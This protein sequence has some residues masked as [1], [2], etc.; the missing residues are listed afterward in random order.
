MTWYN[1][2]KKDDTKAQIVIDGDI[3]RSWWDD[4]SIA[5]N[6]FIA[7]VKALGDLEEIELLINS[8]G[9]SVTD[10]LTIANYL[11][12]HGATVKAKVIGQASSIASVIAA[13]ADEV[14]MGLGSF[15]LI[16]NPWTIG[17]GNAQQLRSLADTLDT[18][19]KSLMDCYIAK[20]GEDKLSQLEQ[21]IKGEDGEGTLL[22][23][24]QWVEIGLA[25]RLDVE[26]QAAAH[27]SPH[28][29]FATLEAA[30]QQRKQHQPAKP[31]LEAKSMTLDELKA[32][33]PKL[34]A[35]LQEEV[36]AKLTDDVNAVNKQAREDAVKAERERVV[37][38]MQACDTYGQGQ[39]AQKLIDKGTDAEFAAEYLADVAAAASS[40]N[41]VNTAHGAGSNGEDASD[42]NRITANYKAFTGKK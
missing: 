29:L 37:A 32:Q 16:H 1:A 26:I 28:K 5:S 39:L 6:Q 2:K 13:A 31:T 25:D 15:G 8:P 38:I 12:G 20:C 21:L 24:E 27:A 42:A 3:G 11:R 22:T 7:S 36:E 33:H 19:G 23:A 40:A 35:A 17:M 18:I 4:D 9:G 34:V 30:R 41:A 14:V 10:G